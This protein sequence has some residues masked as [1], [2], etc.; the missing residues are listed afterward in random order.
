MFSFFTQPRVVEDATAD[1]ILS[2]YLWALQHF[3]AKAFLANTVLVTPTRE[4]FPDKANNELDMVKASYARVLG[5]CGLKDWPFVLANPQVVSQV[6]PPQ[7]G[8]NTLSR[9]NTGVAIQPRNEQDVLLVSYTSAML[10]KPMDLVASMSKSVAQHYLYQSGRMPPGGMETF[11]ETA[12]ILS[13]FMGFGVLVAN[14]AY[15]FRGSCARCY[16][17]NANRVA[18]LSESEAIFSLAVFGVLKELP[19]KDVTKSLKPYL[20]S[21]YKKAVKQVLRNEA[22]LAACRETIATTKA[23][24]NQ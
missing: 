11:N 15:T 6:T 18:S 10:K 12:E 2:V 14:S 21:D 24:G 17:P 22:L 1:N 23:V 13:V 4:S 7:L 5:Y 20:R 19:V 9:S 16:D 8:L 3:D